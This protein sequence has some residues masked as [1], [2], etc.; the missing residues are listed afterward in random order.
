MTVATALLSYLVATRLLA[1]VQTFIDIS[2]PREL[3]PL[4]LALLIGVVADYSLFYL[5]AF[6]RRLGEGEARLDAARLATADFSK[7]ILVAGL[8]VLTGLVVSLALTP[9]LIAVLGRFVFWPNK[10]DSA[11]RDHERPPTFV[12]TVNIRGPCRCPSGAG[13]QARGL[14]SKQWIRHTARGYC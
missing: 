7:V 10:L 14:P 1:I 13:T 8:T 4:I 6:R 5:Y 3:E 9:A 2:V 12:A 11:V